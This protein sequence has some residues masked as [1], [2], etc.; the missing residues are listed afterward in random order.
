MFGG[1]ID[2]KILDSAII[3]VL[4]YIGCLVFKFPNALL[5][6]AFVGITNVIPFFGPFIG[7]IPSILLII[8]VDPMK[9]VWFTI[10]IFGLQ[11]LDGNVIGPKILGDRTGLSSFWVLFSIILCGGLWGLTGMVICVPLFA[12]IYDTVKKL[13]YRGLKSKNQL[14]VWEAYKEEFGEENPKPR[15]AEPEEE[16]REEA[17]PQEMEEA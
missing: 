5:I 14:Q 15:S 12:V 10:F 16:T 11:Q 1:F 9:A 2:G 3:G 6:S 8:I 7:A 13:V 17:P 4:C